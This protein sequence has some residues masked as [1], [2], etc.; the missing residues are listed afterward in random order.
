MSMPGSSLPTP[1][2]TVSVVSHG[3][4]DMVAT[5]LQQLAALHDPNIA[6]VVI[7]HNLPDVD[8]PKPPDATFEL[9][10]LHNP[11]PLGFSAN[12]NRAFAYCETSYF[13]VLNPDIEFQFGNPFPVLLETMIDDARLG[14]VAPALVQPETLHIEPNRRIVTPVEIISRRLP[15]RCP[16]VMPAWLVGA[17]LFIRADAFRALG[18]F[19]ERFRLYCEDVDLGLRMREA[20]WSIRRI[21]SSRVLHQTQRRSHRSLRYTLLHISSLLRLWMRLALRPRYG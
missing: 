2:V 14:A 11:E 21:E 4:R 18:G 6:R 15:G 7:V 20:G 8:L 19:D 1:S 13:A 17:F 5:L 12:H 9:V 3:Q 10:Q 16:P